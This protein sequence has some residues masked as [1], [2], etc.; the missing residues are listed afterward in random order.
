MSF[1]LN[2]LCLFLLEVESN[3]SSETSLGVTSSE[4]EEMRRNSPTADINLCFDS[5]WI[6]QDWQGCGTPIPLCGTSIDNDLC[7]CD[8]LG[9]RKDKKVCHEEVFCNVAP[10]CPNGL[11]NECPPG[12]LCISDSCCGNNPPICVELC[13]SCYDPLD[14]NNQ[15]NFFPSIKTFEGIIGITNNIYD[16]GK[17]IYHNQQINGQQINVLPINN[18]TQCIF[19]INNG[20]KI[21]N[22]YT[23]EICSN[24][25]GKYSG[26]HRIIKCNSQ[27]K[28]PT[29]GKYHL[30]IRGSKNKKIII[31]APKNEY[32]LL[33]PSNGKQ[34]NSPF[35]TDVVVFFDRLQEKSIEY[36]IDCI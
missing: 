12:L 20:F 6:F 30:Q 23:V 28:L 27:I 4:L 19:D 35:G 21:G 24:K 36:Q 1:L 8:I 16:G 29:K 22:T 3:E 13:A 25:S 32:Q 15:C 26:V 14:G 17:C 5:N 2:F 10:K 9:T 34:I 31:N 7:A 18:G 11:D 33:D